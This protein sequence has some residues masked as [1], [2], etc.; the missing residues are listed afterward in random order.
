LCV[1]EH[2]FV[3]FLL[4][5]SS[6]RIA[7]ICDT[8]LTRLRMGIITHIVKGSWLVVSGLKILRLVNWVLWGLNVAGTKVAVE[9]GA[10]GIAK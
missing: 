2:K 7:D 6:L 9:P 1:S 4:S 10:D 8:N 5:Y 3:E